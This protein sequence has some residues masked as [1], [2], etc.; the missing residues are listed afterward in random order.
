MPELV[1]AAEVALQCRQIHSLAAAN[2]AS[3]PRSCVHYPRGHTRGTGCQAGERSSGG[4]CVLASGRVRIERAMPC[5]W[6][7]ARHRPSLSGRHSSKCAMCKEPAQWAL[8]RDPRKQ[9]SKV[10]AFGP[11]VRAPWKMKLA[12]MRALGWKA[13]RSAVQVTPR[14]SR[15]RM[16]LLW[17]RTATESCNSC[18]NPLT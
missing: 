15:P 17:K 18:R 8:Q 7:P 3:S 12:V 14:L 1:T 4:F 13:G 5:M 16:L 9:G 2:Q 11:T 6:A 10:T